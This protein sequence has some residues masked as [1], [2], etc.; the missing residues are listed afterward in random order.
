MT[1]SLTNKLHL[2]QQLYSHRL[3]EG[4]SLED[5]LTTFKEIVSDLETLEVKYDKE[6]L[7]LILL[8]S[9]PSSYSTF[10]DTIPYSCETLTIEK[11][12]E[13]LSSYE[14]MKHLCGWT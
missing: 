2:K 3:S 6:D 10:R 7:G 14:K 11:I 4:A 1:K 8:C 5:H 13:A 9:L 12:Y